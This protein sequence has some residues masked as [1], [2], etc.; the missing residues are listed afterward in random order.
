MILSICALTAISTPNTVQLAQARLRML[1]VT[2]AGLATS[3]TAATLER[4]HGGQRRCSPETSAHLRFLETLPGF[5]SKCSATFV[6]CS[7]SSL[8]RQTLHLW[9]RIFG[10][11]MAR[12]MCLWWHLPSQTGRS[13]Y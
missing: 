11:Q 7:S 2:P 1:A 8:A 4:L 12:Q 3:E 13:A 6:T 10:R 9:A 5:I